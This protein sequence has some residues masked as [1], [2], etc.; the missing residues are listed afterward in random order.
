MI[1]NTIQKK[2]KINGL[3]FKLSI[4]SYID[5]VN[6]VSLITNAVDSCF[7]DE[8]EFLFSSKDAIWA[9]YIMRYFTNIDDIADSIDLGVNPLSPEFY[10]VLAHYTSVIDDIYNNSDINIDSLY[11][12]YCDGIQHRL[13]LLYNPLRDISNAVVSLID[14]LQKSFKDMENVDIQQIM[15]LA[16]ELALKDEGKIVDGILGFHSK[17]FKE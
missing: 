11:S 5:Y 17:E 2:Y 4:K 16:Q 8:D 14:K 7:T 9:T 3:K 1:G 15:S 13:A 10:W 6:V 12:E